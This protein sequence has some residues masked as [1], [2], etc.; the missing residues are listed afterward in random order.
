MNWYEE[1]QEAKRQRLE[2][3]ADRLT[4]EGAARVKSGFDRL[5]LIPFG[6]PILVGHH[7]EKGDRSYRRKACNSIDKGFELQK[8]GGELAARAASIGAAGVSS[9]DP[10]GVEKL[11]EQLNE[12]K[13]KQEKM[14]LVN[15]LVRKQDREGLI[16][17]G[18]AAKLVDLWLEKPSWGGKYRAYEPYELSNNNANI[19][20]IEQRI[21]E[22]SANATRETKVTEA[23]DVKLVENAEIN[24]VQLI[25]PGKP[26][27]EIRT[28]LK[29]RG[30]RWSP[31]EGAWQR[32]LNGS[33]VYAA[34]DILHFLTKE[35]ATS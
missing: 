12:R 30:F 23:G 18:F 7:S 4:R 22:L 10:D 1:K 16:A 5:S 21:K 15:K 11:T 20:R 31:M 19:R 35:I 24:R 25:F 17:A 8:A 26:N 14:A 34:K 6:Q 28:L 9:D 27:A 2:D 3:R 32:H 13:A 29:S 33:G